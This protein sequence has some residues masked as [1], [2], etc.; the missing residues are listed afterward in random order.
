MTQSQKLRFISC[1]ANEK[2]F[3]VKIKLI[4]MLRLMLRHPGL[5]RHRILVK[6]ARTGQPSELET[7]WANL[8]PAL[9]ASLMF[10]QY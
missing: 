1:Q 9:C 2:E 3:L 4:V 5:A 6:H 7:P 8:M 10:V